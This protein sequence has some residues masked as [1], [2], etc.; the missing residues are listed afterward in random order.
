MLEPKVKSK[1]RSGPVNAHA[2]WTNR[3]AGTGL[4]VHWLTG[5]MNVPS[6]PGNFSVKPLL[7]RGRWMPSQNEGATSS[8]IASWSSAGVAHFGTLILVRAPPLLPLLPTPF[9]SRTG[10]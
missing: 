4:V 9:F 10:T 3:R 5:A 6:S 2:P 1:S 8:S 7:A